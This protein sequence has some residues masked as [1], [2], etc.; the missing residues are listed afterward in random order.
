MP[1]TCTL[2]N[3]PRRD[4]VDRALL[5]GGW[6]AEKQ[7]VQGKVRAD[8]PSDWVGPVRFVGP[9]SVRVR[10]QGVPVPFRLCRL[11]GV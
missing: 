4:G 9:P 10:L 7:R 5:A 6:Q 1:R 11:G 2:C 8:S 3:H